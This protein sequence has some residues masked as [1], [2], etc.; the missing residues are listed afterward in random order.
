MTRATTSRRTASSTSPA[1]TSPGLTSGRHGCGEISRAAL[2]ALVALEDFVQC[3]QQLDP[4]AA[5]LLLEILDRL[6]QAR[7][8]VR[9]FTARPEHGLRATRAAQQV[10]RD[11]GLVR[12]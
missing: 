7:D 9:P 8:D 3:S 11:R 5:P 1:S 2:A 12:E 6:R 10:E 4:V